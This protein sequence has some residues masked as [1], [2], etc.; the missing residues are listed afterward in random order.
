MYRIPHPYNVAANDGRASHLLEDG[1]R[2]RYNC[3]YKLASKENKWVGQKEDGMYLRRI[4]IKRKRKSRGNN[5][6]T[7]ISNFYTLAFSMTSSRE[8]MFYCCIHMHSFFSRLQPC[9]P[10]VHTRIELHH[11]CNTKLTVSSLYYVPSMGSFFIIE[12]QIVS[13]LFDKKGS[14]TLC[15]RVYVYQWYMKTCTCVPSVLAFIV[16]GHGFVKKMTIKPAYVFI[17]P[18]A[19]VYQYALVYGLNG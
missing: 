17:Y 14:I 7:D 11:T 13:N 19:H 9:L 15:M 1:I 4:L 3:V 10:F 2:R 8:I 12:V 6:D 16:C 18:A 5:F